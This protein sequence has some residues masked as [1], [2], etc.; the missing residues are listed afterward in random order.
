MHEQPLFKVAWTPYDHRMI[1]RL[2][3]ESL[4]TQAPGHLM[5]KS[6]YTG[7]LTTINFHGSSHDQQ[8][9]WVIARPT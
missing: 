8:L 5:T 4:Q 2:T 9:I 1:I 7:R 3:S 6:T